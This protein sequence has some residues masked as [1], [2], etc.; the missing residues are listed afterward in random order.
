MSFASWLGQQQ[1]AENTIA[2]QLARIERIRRVYPELDAQF[3]R[4]SFSSLQSEFVYTRRDEREGRP[5]P[6]RLV[7]E[8]NLYH[9][10]ATYRATLGRY[11][12]YMQSCSSAPPPRCVDSTSEETESTSAWPGFEIHMQRALRQ[13]IGQLARD[14]RIDDDG[15]E[16]RVESG[17]IDI[18]ARDTNGRIVVIELKTGTAGQR[19]VAQ[20]LS[21]MG[22]MATEDDTSE[23][24]GILVAFDFD[25]KARAAAKM[26]ST[27]QLIEYRFQFEFSKLI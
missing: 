5:N 23:V 9:N 13:N 12:R 21:Y 19:A 10:L 2:S 27:L 3:E 26:V 14:L 8:G 16:R 24:R 1:Y 7:I 20:I 25:H 4:D 17:F 15:V 11:M 18:T 6:T 22:D